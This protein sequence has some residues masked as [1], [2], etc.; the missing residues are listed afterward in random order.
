M[1]CSYQIYW[2]SVHCFMYFMSTIRVIFLD[3]DKESQNGA[4][5]FTLF[6]EWTE[7]YCSLGLS[8]FEMGFQSCR[9]LKTRIV[10][11]PILTCQLMDIKRSSRV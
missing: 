3:F 10:L 2:F 1:L 5:R 6:S 11:L 4:Q 9:N 8:S 7:N